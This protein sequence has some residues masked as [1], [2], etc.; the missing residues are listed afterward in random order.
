MESIRGLKGLR[1]G[2]GLVKVEVTKDVDSHHTNPDYLTL[3]VSWNGDR[4]FRC[5]GDVHDWLPTDRELMEVVERLAS[6]S[7]TFRD[8]VL[9]W[10][11]SW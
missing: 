2:W 3:R 10:A 11:V 5:R 4:N 7:V 9:R 8:M 1:G 6:V